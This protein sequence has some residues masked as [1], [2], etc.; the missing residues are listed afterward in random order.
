MAEIPKQSASRHEAMQKVRRGQSFSVELPL[1]GRVPL[2]RPE[3]LAFYGALGVLAA[4]EIIEWP[5]ALVLG[6]GHFLVQEDH[7]RVVQEIG[8]ALEEA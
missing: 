6:S 7:N 2:P 5:V 8:E 1:I 4:V 3:Q